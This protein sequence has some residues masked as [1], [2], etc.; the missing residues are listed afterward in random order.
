MNAVEHLPVNEKV[1]HRHATLARQARAVER[2]ERRAAATSASAWTMFGPKPAELQRRAPQA[3]SGLDGDARA[4]RAGEGDEVDARIAYDRLAHRRTAVQDVEDAGREARVEKICAS[5][6][7]QVGASGGALNTTALPAAMA[8]PTLW[9]A[10]LN[11]ALNGTMAPTTPTGKR[12]S[13]ASLPAPSSLPSSGTCLPSMRI[14]SSAQKPIVSAERL[15]SMR[16]SL[17]ALPVSSV[18]AQAIA[19]LRSRISACTLLRRSAR[20]Y[21]G[22]A[23]AHAP[24]PPWRSLGRRSL[25]SL[26]PPSSPLC[27]Y[28]GRRRRRSRRR[29]TSHRR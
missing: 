16:V 26:R 24:I 6:W 17:S 22:A 27:H 28:R 13:M 29:R 2:A 14:A 5:I 15:T 23:A 18:M 11:G 8:G 7:M 3:C 9:Q 20:R 21:P 1:L 10:M 25:D 19:S 4:R 12:S